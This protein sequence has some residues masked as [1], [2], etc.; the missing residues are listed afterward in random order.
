M[1]KKHGHSESANKF[2]MEHY[3]C[4]QNNTHC[5]LEASGIL[6]TQTHPIEHLLGN[7][8]SSLQINNMQ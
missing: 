5:K 2:L 7:T 3:F 6:L 8:S 1:L 4:Q